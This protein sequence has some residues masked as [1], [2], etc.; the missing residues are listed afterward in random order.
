VPV[1]PFSQFDMVP[2]ARLNDALDNI[3]QVAYQTNIQSDSIGADTVSNDLRFLI[4]PSALYTF[5]SCLIYEATTAADIWFQFYY[6]G[7]TELIAPLGADT[8]ATTT[9]NNI[10][11]NATS[12]TAL[13]R[14]YGG[15]GAG[16]MMMANPS[17]MFRNSAT[18]NCYF[19]VTFAKNTTDVNDTS[20]AVLHRDSWI[21]ITRV[22]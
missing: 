6:L 14:F 10:Q 22:A 5:E 4:V 7:G 18:K 13:Q 2:S 8:T 9:T 11:Q 20:L 15:A 17:G 3:R 21:A 16:V 1:I 19:G 12:G